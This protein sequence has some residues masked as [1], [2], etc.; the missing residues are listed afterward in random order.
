MESAAT[1]LAQVEARIDHACRI[2]RRERSAV[3]LIAVSKTQPPDAI[4]PLIA[5]GQRVFG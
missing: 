5:A 1:L 2:A 4:A 3:T